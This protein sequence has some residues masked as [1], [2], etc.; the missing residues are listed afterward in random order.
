MI[1]HALLLCVLLVSPAVADEP[2]DQL[3]TPHYHA[4]PSDPA[5]LTQAVQLHGHLGPA[6]IAGVRLGMAGLRAVEAKGYFDVE[7]TCEGP[8]AKPPQSC[9]L[10]GLQMGTGATLGKRTLH[11]IQADQ[12]VVRVKNLQTGK[13][14]ELRPKPALLDLLA[15]FKPQP[16][17]AAESSGDHHVDDEHLEAIARKIAL[18]PRSQLAEIRII[19]SSAL[20]GSGSDR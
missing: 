19:D 13:I 11:W 3:P 18:L 8:M 16:K 4:L 10:D 7:V 9:F 2:V 17:V 14:A 6:A 5:W 1:R 20:P 12:I 15:S